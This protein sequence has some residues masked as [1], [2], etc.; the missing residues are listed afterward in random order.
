MG[1]EPPEA[2]APGELDCGN[3]HLESRNVEGMR[4]ILPTFV[5]CFQSQFG[6]SYAWTNLKLRR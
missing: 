4:F 6:M 5:F 3:C 1:I 2:E